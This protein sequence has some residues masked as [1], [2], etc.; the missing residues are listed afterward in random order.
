M[1]SP[2]SKVHMTKDS[3][4]TRSPYRT[5]TRSRTNSGRALRKNGGL[6]K[7]DRV[8]GLLRG[9]RG[10]TIATI[11]KATGWQPHSIRGF[12][13]GVVK[14]KLRLALV[15]EKTKSGRVY[16][17]PPDKVLVA[18]PSIEVKLERCRA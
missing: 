6:T 15:S 7:H 3:P 2:T 17:I 9:K 14:N 1:V 11:S 5:T 4:K 16:R 13:P 12:F 8:L 10:A 18:A